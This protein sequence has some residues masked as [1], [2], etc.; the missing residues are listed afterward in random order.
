MEL[1]S[2][3]RVRY[4]ELMQRC[5]TR[6]IDDKLYS[7]HEMF[8][9]GWLGNILNPLIVRYLRKRNLEVV[10]SSTWYD[11]RDG[12]DW[13]VNA[14]TMVGLKRLRNVKESLETCIF[15]NI[16]G[17]FV[18]C[19]VWRGGASI[20]ASATLIAY[21]EDDKR[22]IWACDSFEGLPKPVCSLDKGDFHWSV[23]TLKVSQIDVMKNFEKYMVNNAN[24]NF[25]K[26]WFGQTLPLL[27]V[28][29]IAVLR[30]DGDMYQS[31]WEILTSLYEKVVPRGFVIIDDYYS[32]EQCRI[33]FDDFSNNNSVIIEDGVVVDNACFCFRKGIG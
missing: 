32:C 20:M 22:D 28:E 7:T 17:D 19:G 4:L 11:R 24:V 27:P 10:S 29:K 2:E 5:L 14:E 31:T 23:E 33:A 18:E 15:E 30:L 9:K 26:G 25:I 12:T 1:E 3:L 13:P 16:P 21:G 6:S 8:F